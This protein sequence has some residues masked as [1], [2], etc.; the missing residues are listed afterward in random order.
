MPVALSDEVILPKVWHWR[1]V[2]RVVITD[3]KATSIYLDESRKWNRDPAEA[4]HGQVAY[5]AIGRTN[6]IR[7]LKVE[8]MI[9]I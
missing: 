1:N 8:T 3:G 9:D 7:F 5:E 2:E 4:V 6:A